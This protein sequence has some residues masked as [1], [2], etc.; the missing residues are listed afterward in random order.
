MNQII[1][2]RNDNT[3]KA[4][5]KLKQTNDLGQSFVSLNSHICSICSERVNS[6]QRFLICKQCYNP[7]HI[8]CN[9]ISPKEYLKIC[10]ESCDRNWVCL[11]C[12][13]KNAAE[14]IPFTL[15]TDE[16]LFTLSSINTPSLTNQVP[17]F[18]INS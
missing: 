17:S 9:D 11:L 12:T 1:K 6:N 14:I 2:P 18:E 3:L 5:E 15:E 4:V 7:V 10:A 16:S 8:S 13:V